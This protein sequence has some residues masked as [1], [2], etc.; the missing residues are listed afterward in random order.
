MVKIS[1]R[2]NISER[3]HRSDFYLVVVSHILKKLQ[4]KEAVLA[5]TITEN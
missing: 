3:S 5:A 4:Q 1:V 2:G